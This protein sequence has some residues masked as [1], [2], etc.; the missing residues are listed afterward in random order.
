M[1]GRD[2]EIH[3]GVE[4]ERDDRIDDVRLVARP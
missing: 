4:V 1:I 2:D 3:S